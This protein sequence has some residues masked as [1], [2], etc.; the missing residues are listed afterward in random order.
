MLS[1][2]KSNL[3]VLQGLEQGGMEGLAGGKSSREVTG[4]GLG[5]GPEDE[6]EPAGRRRPA[7]TKGCM[8]KAG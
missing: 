3:R 2:K 4:S 1:L 8:H 7:R 5:A 6:T